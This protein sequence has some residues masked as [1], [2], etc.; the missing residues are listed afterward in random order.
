MRRHR[1]REDGVQ[2]PFSWKCLLA[3]LVE[4]LT[5]SFLNHEVEYMMCLAIYKYIIYVTSGYCVCDVTF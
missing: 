1:W 3:K 4:E 2:R 5:S